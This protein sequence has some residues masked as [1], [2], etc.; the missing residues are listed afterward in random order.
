MSKAAVTPVHVGIIMDG[1]RRWART[2]G[3]PAWRGH[4]KG[5]EVLRLIAR[6]AFKSGIKYLT[7]YAF[8]TENWKRHKKEVNYLMRHVSLA[9]KKYIHE[10]VEADV[11]IIFL[12]SH[13]GLP[14]TVLQAI[15]EAEAKT[16]QNR[17]ATFAICL[18][19][20]GLQEIADAT[21]QV[22]ASGAS[23]EAVTPEVIA[24]YLYGSH[25]PPL[26][27]IIRTGGEQR[28]SNFMLWRAAYAELYFIETLWPEFTEADLQVA[29][30]EYALRQRRFGT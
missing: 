27:L 23:A 21:K 28:L 6:Q 22:I 10:F 15:D 1:S 8:S 9:L 26:D 24:S 19:Y 18:N 12:A 4:A 16:A 2:R 14:K 25:I 3:W 11:K 7:V 13:E 20:G 30:D 29:L 5:Q 17:A